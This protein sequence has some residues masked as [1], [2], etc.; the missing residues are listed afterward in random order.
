M[1]LRGGSL[2]DIDLGGGECVAGRLAPIGLIAK[3]MEVP[4]KS[5]DFGLPVAA[6]RQSFPVHGLQPTARSARPT[7]PKPPRILVSLPLDSP[8]RPAPGSVRASGRE[9]SE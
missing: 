1:Q 5:F 9:R 7:L 6:R 8:N 4:T 3:R 2:D